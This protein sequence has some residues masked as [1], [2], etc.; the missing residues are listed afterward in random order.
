MFYDIAGENADIIQKSENK[1]ETE[2]QFRGE[3]PAQGANEFDNEIDDKQNGIPHRPDSAASTR[4]IQSPGEP[5]LFSLNF[6]IL[7]I[8]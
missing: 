7:T 3:D 5:F 1:E 8:S 2:S 4:E 6:I